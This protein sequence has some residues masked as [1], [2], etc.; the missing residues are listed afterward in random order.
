MPHVK[1]IVGVSATDEVHV[2]DLELDIGPVRLEPLHAGGDLFVL[3]SAQGKV[4][5]EDVGVQDV[6][7]VAVLWEG[8]L[9]AR[10]DLQNAVVRRIR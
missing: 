4:R 5:R 2:R 9:E 1:R 3:E 10:V 6:A 7:E 8:A